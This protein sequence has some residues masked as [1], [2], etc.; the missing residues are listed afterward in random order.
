MPADANDTGINRYYK[1]E[2]RLNS[3]RC[4]C[5]AD[6]TAWPGVGRP[7]RMRRTS[8]HYRRQRSVRTCIRRPRGDRTATVAA[9]SAPRAFL[10]SLRWCTPCSA[11]WPRPVARW[12]VHRPQRRLAR[13]RDGAAAEF[14]RSKNLCDVPNNRFTTIA[15]QA[16]FVNTFYILYLR[17][18]VTATRITTRY[19]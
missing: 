15:S 5:A 10:V 6:C 7:H 2:T 16:V 19:V 12:T 4:D 9:A 11:S 18:R 1:E 8:C 17:H 14:V 3:P 13:C